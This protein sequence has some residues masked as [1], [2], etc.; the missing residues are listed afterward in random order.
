LLYGRDERQSRVDDWG[1]EHWDAPESNIETQSG[2]IEIVDVETKG[3]NVETA[4]VRTKG[5]RVS[6]VREGETE[7]G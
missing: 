5:S 4:A 6:H 3:G 1:G 2:E 7:S